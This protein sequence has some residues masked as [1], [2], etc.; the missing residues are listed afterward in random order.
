[1]RRNGLGATA[2]VLVVVGYSSAADA[3]PSEEEAVVETEFL[4]DAPDVERREA[5][6]WVWTLGLATQVAFNDNR[7]VVGEQEGSTASLGYKFETLFDY[8]ENQ[9]GFRSGLTWTE[10][11]T[12][13]PTIDPVI[14]SEDSLSKEAIYSYYLTPYFG[15][16]VRA[17]LDTPVFKGDDVRPTPTTYVITRT[18]GTV[19]TVVQTRLPLTDPLRPFTLKQSLGPFA[20]PARSDEFNLELRLGVGARETLAEDQLAVTD[21]EATADV[22]E[23][24]E[25][26]DVYQ[27]GVEAAASTWGA[28][29]KELFAYKAGAEVMVPF[30]S[31]NDD[32]RSAWELTNV[33]VFVGLAFR[34]TNFA[35]LDYQFKLKREPQLVDAIQLQNNL[36]LSLGVNMEVDRREK[37]EPP[38]EEGD[39]P[40]PAVK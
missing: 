9:H 4:A 40:P 1:M 3:Q 30:A 33:E 16:F 38:P 22:V 37:K 36:L 31:N 19:D 29:D 28:I 18:D 6:G 17:S 13:T 20:R 14:K 32:D 25:L 24:T 2:L 34:L 23:V 10:G 11:L 7:G 12:K 39:A 27:L 26:A 8:Y 21:D 15:P 5:E 35:S